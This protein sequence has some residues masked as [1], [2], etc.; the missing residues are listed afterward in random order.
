MKHWISLQL[1]QLICWILLNFV[2]AVWLFCG[3]VSF[4]HL[5]ICPFV[6]LSICPFVIDRHNYCWGIF[7]WICDSIEM[8]LIIGSVH[9][10]YALFETKQIVNIYQYK[11]IE[12]NGTKQT[13]KKKT[14][15]I[16]IPFWMLIT[17]IWIVNCCLLLPLSID[18][19]LKQQMSSVF[20]HWHSIHLRNTIVVTVASVT[21]EWWNTTPKTTHSQFEFVNYS[22]SFLFNQELDCWR[23]LV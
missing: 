17:V 6:H 21:K 1:Y 15:E 8:S 7:V 13:H 18:S 4:T 23:H 12:K 20:I 14:R 10:I 11:Y 3:C 16:C 19:T 22:S 9:I 5:S 2:K